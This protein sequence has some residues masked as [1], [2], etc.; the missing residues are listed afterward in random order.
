MANMEHEHIESVEHENHE[1]VHA[2]ERERLDDM[3]DN[4]SRT[5]EKEAPDQVQEEQ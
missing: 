4:T 1:S 5:H 3:I 2:E